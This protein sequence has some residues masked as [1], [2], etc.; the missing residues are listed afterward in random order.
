MRCPIGY[1][2]LRVLKILLDDILMSV[3]DDDALVALVHALTQHIVHR[4]VGVNLG[5]DSVNASVL[6]RCHQVDIAHNEGLGAIAVL[7][8]VDCTGSTLIHHLAHIFDLP[9]LQHV[10]TTVQIVLHGQFNRI[11]LT[12]GEAG[13]DAFLGSTAGDGHDGQVIS[14]RG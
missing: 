5:L 6:A 10:G 9:H 13:L 2:G 8:S 7:K 11:P 14:C 3:L 4:L 1:N 12:A